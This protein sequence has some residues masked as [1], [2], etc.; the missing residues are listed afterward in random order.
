[1][2]RFGV[3]FIADEETR[4]VADNFTRKSARAFVAE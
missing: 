2:F 3:A 1:L 4:L